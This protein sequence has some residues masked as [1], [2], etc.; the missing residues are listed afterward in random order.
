MNR[1]MLALLALLWM[2]NQAATIEN[3]SNWSDGFV[4]LHVTE[5][6]EGCAT[7]MGGTL[8]E[9]GYQVC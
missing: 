3:G 7:L 1:T 5:V 2:S 8:H 4:I 6:H 9:G